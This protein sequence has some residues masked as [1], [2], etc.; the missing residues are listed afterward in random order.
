[1]KDNIKAK[2][3]KLRNCFRSEKRIAEAVMASADYTR[4]VIGDDVCKHKTA[5]GKMT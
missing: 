3:H 1:M 5:R 2:I 4:Y